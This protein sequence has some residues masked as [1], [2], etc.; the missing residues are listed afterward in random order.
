[1]DGT[2]QTRI[3]T[4]GGE[5]VVRDGPRGEQVSERAWW[6]GETLV[7]ETVGSRMTMTRRLSRSDDGKQLVSDVTVELQG[8]DKAIEAT[9]VYNGI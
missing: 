5:R 7:L 2:D 4:P 6:D 9:L 3:W 8:Q 1:M